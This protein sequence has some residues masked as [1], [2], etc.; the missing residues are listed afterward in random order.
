MSRRN[1]KA[2]RHPSR[3]YQNREQKKTPAV[4]TPA[5]NT[6]PV[7]RPA[8]YGSWSQSLCTHWQEPFRLEGGLSVTA[9]AYTDRPWKTGTHALS[10]RGLRAPD[11]GVYFD[12][13]W[14]SDR[15]FMTPG[16]RPS[17]VGPKRHVSVFDAKDVVIYP[18]RDGSDPDNLREFC[19]AAEWIIDMLGTDKTVDIGCVGG[20]GRT[21]TML[22]TLLVVQSVPARDAIKR[23]HTTYCEEAVETF[24][25]ASFIVRV[26]NIRN[27]RP[28]NDGLFQH[29]PS[30]KTTTTMTQSDLAFTEDVIEGSE[31][32]MQ[33]YAH[34][35]ENR[36]TEQPLTF[37]QWMRLE[38]Q[39]WPS[40][41][42]RGINSPDA[43]CVFPPCI[44][45]TTCDPWAGDCFA[46]RLATA[47]TL[48]KL[49]TEPDDEELAREVH[50]RMTAFDP[51]VVGCDD[52]EG[53][54]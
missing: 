47:R 5:A 7:K 31:A 52:Y 8:A 36:E 20:H 33:A 38:R 23:V 39:A 35:L 46:S 42:P 28:I 53:W 24:A 30:P 34:Y 44:N 49:T 15:M 12:D 2:R 22:A 50:N 45:P 3:H 19:R 48:E 18:M 25:Q 29:T 27:G 1:K 4:A 43:M 16:F 32:D 14:T 26:D 9:S 37:D 40:D 13:I 6:P 54:D 41:E 11:F 51:D 10:T 17:F 21:G